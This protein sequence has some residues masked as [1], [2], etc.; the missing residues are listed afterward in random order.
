MVGEPAG[1]GPL[2][3]SPR[4]S[5]VREPRQLLDCA[6]NGT[7]EVILAKLPAARERDGVEGS[8]RELMRRGEGAETGAQGGRASPRPSQKV[9][10]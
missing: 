8:A 2:G 1:D 4:L 9:E 5:Q 10:R 6:R 3:C 7:G